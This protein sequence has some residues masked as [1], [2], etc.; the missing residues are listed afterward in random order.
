MD[1]AEIVKNEETP[2]EETDQKVIG[3]FKRGSIIL[4]LLQNRPD[5]ADEPSQSST[6]GTNK[7]VPQEQ[8]C[9]A[10]EECPVCSEPFESQG[11]RSPALLHCNHTV[12]QRCVWGVQC[13]APDPS[14]LRCPLCRQTTPLPQWDIFS[15]QEEMYSSSVHIYEAELAGYGTDLRPSSRLCCVPSPCFDDRLMRIHSLY[16]Y[17]TALVLLLLLLG[18]LLYRD[19]S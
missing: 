16:F 2:V 10:A 6:D 3:L 19:R 4:P 12:C 18:Y 9:C 15:R 1:E 17:I 5:G 11:E 13:R 7:S 8:G 14:R